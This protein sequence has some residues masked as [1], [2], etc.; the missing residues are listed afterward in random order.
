V[1]QVR[2]A[3]E[4]RTEFG[5]GA[6]RRIR[7]AHKV[8]AVLYGHGTEPRHISL[9]GH[10][11]MLALKG[12]ANT[13][14][15]IDV[16][17]GTELS[18]PKQVTRDP[19]RGFLEHCDLLLV[20][21]GEKVVVDVPVIL[22]GQAALE[23]LVDHQMTTISVEAEATHIPQSFEVSIEGLGVGASVHAG[24]VPLP[25]GVTLAG[26]PD[27]VVVHIL[28]QVTAEALEAELAE[29]AAELA[30]AEAAEPAAEAEAAA[31]EEAVEGEAA[32]AEEGARDSA[33]E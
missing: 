25:S 5:K 9:P 23:T 14:L 8:P 7:R 1:A 24:E 17:G 20:R 30:P 16:D 29:A 10:E 22:N 31:P 12:G 2:I 33:G 21:R 18:L 3:A 13:L 32:P 15:E 6:A 26:D 4:P 19:V 27:A 11:L 28:A